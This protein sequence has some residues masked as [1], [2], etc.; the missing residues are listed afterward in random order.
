MHNFFPKFVLGIQCF[1]GTN[2]ITGYVVFESFP[3]ATHPKAQISNLFIKALGTLSHSIL[4]T[5]PI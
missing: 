4:E 2:I 3:F 1:V 5:A